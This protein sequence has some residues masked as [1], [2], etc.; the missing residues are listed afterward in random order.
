[1]IDADDDDHVQDIDIGVLVVDEFVLI[2][3]LGEDDDEDDFVLVAMVVSNESVDEE[4]DFGCML[5]SEAV[6][7]FGGTPVVQLLVV[8]GFVEAV[9]VAVAIVVAIGLSGVSWGI[10]VQLVVG[11]VKVP[12]FI[13]VVVLVRALGG[14]C[15]WFKEKKQ[16]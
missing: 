15:C 13:I 3:I 12:K 6:I 10:N 11:T 14:G 7:P 5:I 4:D 8:D 16:N 1:M 9:V 2:L